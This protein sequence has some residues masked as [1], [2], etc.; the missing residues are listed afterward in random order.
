MLAKTLTRRYFLATSGAAATGA[1]MNAALPGLAFADSSMIKPAKK[2]LVFVMLDGGNDSFNMLV[3]NDGIAYKE[4][5]RTRGNLALGQ[6]DLIAL[7]GAE[8]HG[9]S[10]GLHRA[11]PELAQLYNSG[12]LSFVANVGPLVEK[13]T[14]AQFYDGS[15]QLPLGLLSHADQFK[16][17]QTSRPDVR[18]NEGWFGYFADELQQSRSAHEI[19]MNISLAGHNIAQNGKRDL[20]YAI[21]KEGSVGLYVKEERTPL[22]DLLND[23]FNR[24]MSADQSGDPFKETYLRLTRNAQA[25]HETFAAAT[26]GIEAPGRFPETDLAQQLK[27][28]ARTIA[29]SD[30]LGLEQQTFF[31]RYIGWDHHDELLDTHAGMLAVLSQALGA[32]QSALEDMG[33]SDR[34]VT[35][36]GSDF[37]RTLTSNGNGS[38]HGWGGNTL[39]MGD[40][41]VGGRIF[42]DYPILGL[43]DDNPLDVGDGV[44]IPTTSTDQLYA[45]LSLWFGVQD[46][47]LSEIFPNLTRFAAPGERLGLFG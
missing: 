32:F 25:Q 1:L 18:Q 41:I 5:A 2:A 26:K 19:G 15:A 30:R 45:D 8:N 7:D 20:P 28:V 31:V 9:Q 36:T 42:G 14:K 39:V 13:I 21:T 24:M 38:D 6:G 11:A 10:F 4:Y 12:K 16:H 44:L 47:A 37:G 43:G 22:N 27:M 34:V 46:A 40:P 3:P 33:L 35:F 29:A 17:W 23:S